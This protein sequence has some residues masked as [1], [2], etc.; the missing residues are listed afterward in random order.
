MIQD[1]LGS[2]RARADKEEAMFAALRQGATTLELLAL[3][4][5]PVQG[6]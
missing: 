5:S 1:V 4:P 3:D 6:A 2:G